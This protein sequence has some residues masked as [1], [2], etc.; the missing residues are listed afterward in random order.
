MRSLFIFFF[1]IFYTGDYDLI[2]CKIFV[3]VFIES[4][5]EISTSACSSVDRASV[6]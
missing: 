5:G 3:Y 1:L 2:F 6:S 4:E